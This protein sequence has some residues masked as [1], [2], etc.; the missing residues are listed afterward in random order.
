MDDPHLKRLHKSQKTP[1]QKDL[2]ELMT[3]YHVQE[4]SSSYSYLHLRN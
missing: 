1:I 4:T 2:Q 3:F